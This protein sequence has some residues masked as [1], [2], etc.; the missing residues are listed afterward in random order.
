MQPA[1][2][3]ETTENASEPVSLATNQD[4]IVQNDHESIPSANTE[5]LPSN[6]EHIPETKNSDSSLVMSTV[7]VKYCEQRQVIANGV[8]DVFKIRFLFFFASLSLFLTLTRSVYFI[9]TSCRKKE[10]AA[11]EKATSTASGITCS[12][13][14]SPLHPPPA[15]GLQDVE[16]FVIAMTRLMCRAYKFLQI[17]QHL[18]CNSI[19]NLFVCLCVRVRVPVCV[20]V[21]YRMH[22]RLLHV[23]VRLYAHSI[24]A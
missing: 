24:C 10:S 21:S 3:H 14:D 11:A 13:Y 23:C 1:D 22:L 20:C 5:Q 2:A 4:E 6:P 16:R 8:H 17:F 9:H 18:V 15:D 19:H 12:K 7:T